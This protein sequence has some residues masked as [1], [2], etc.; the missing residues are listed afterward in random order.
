M[1]EENDLTNIEFCG[2][3]FNYAVNGADAIVILTEWD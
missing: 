3:D 1:G 2:N